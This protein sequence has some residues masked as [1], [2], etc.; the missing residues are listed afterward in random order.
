MNGAPR[1]TLLQR[2]HAWYRR[3]DLEPWEVR[4][5]VFAVVIGGTGIAASIHLFTSGALKAPPPRVE[6]AMRRAQLIPEGAKET[7]AYYLK[8]G[9][10]LL[11]C[12]LVGSTDMDPGEGVHRSAALGGQDIVLALFDSTD[13][14][15]WVRTIGSAGDDHCCTLFPSDTTIYLMGLFQ[16]GVRCAD[17]QHQWELCPNALPDGIR[18]VR[19]ARSGRLLWARSA[20]A[21]RA[22]TSLRVLCERLRLPGYGSMH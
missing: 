8:D 18:I 22:D 6:R 15:Q 19:F 20:E 14:V 21:M 11:A 16:G 4:A 17:E 5:A 10:Q 12:G 13:Q 2:C 3:L 7:T 9:V 1:P